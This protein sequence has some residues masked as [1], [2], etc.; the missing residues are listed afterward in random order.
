MSKGFTLL[1]P[2]FHTH[3]KVYTFQLLEKCFS[4]S[5]Y[6]SKSYPR[7]THLQS[8]WKKI[9]NTCFPCVLLTPS[10]NPRRSPSSTLLKQWIAPSIYIQN[11]LSKY[12]C[13]SMQPNFGKL[14]KKERKKEKPVFKINV[15][16]CWR[17]DGEVTS[18]ATSTEEKIITPLKEHLHSIPLR[19]VCHQD[20]YLKTCALLA[21]VEHPKEKP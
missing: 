10:I 5:I 20:V 17:K 21:A 7:N 16:V 2:I 3:I 9:R 4:R 19:I 13:R 6:R 11:N 1:L 14:Q 12:S 18:S 8:R 15:V